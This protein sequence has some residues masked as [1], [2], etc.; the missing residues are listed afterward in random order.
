MSGIREQRPQVKPFQ[1]RIQHGLTRNMVEGADGTDRKHG[2]S[3][4]SLCGGAEQA[5]DSL[6]AGTCAEPVLV[7]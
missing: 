2:G 6:S 5:D 4:V 3:G 7:R 1:Q